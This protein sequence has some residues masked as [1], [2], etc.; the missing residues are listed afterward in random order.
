MHADIQRYIM[1]KPMQFH[2]VLRWL[3]SELQTLLPDHH[4]CLSYA[5]PGFRNSR[6]KMVI[7]YAAFTHHVGLYPH[8]GAVISQI[9][10]SPFRTSKSGIM[11][12]PDHPPTVHLI[13]LIIQTRQAQLDVANAR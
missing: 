10:C 1:E 7:G 13:N 11:F 12:A 6:G 2:P 4:E 3:H 9:D 5:M 8:S